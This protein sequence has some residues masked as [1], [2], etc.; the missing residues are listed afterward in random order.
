LFDLWLERPMFTELGMVRK[1]LVLTALLVLVLVAC[2]ST[3]TSSTLTSTTTTELIST[4]QPLA[5]T[6]L[7]TV[8]TP[9]PTA[10]FTPEPVTPLLPGIIFRTAEGVWLVNVRDESELLA[11]VPREGTVD[12]CSDGSYV[13]YGAHRHETDVWVKDYS[14]IEVS[15]GQQVKLEPGEDYVFCSVEWLA[16][17]CDAALAIVEPLSYVGSREC[18]GVPAILDLKSNRL[19]LLGDTPSRHSLFSAVSLDGGAVAFW[20]EDEPWIWTEGGGS[21]VLDLEAYNFPAE[22]VR[23]WNPA[24]SPSGNQVAWIASGVVDGEGSSRGLS[25]LS[26]RQIRHGSYAHIRFG[27]WLM[28]RVMSP[29]VRMATT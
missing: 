1:Q 24:W 14:V 18:W 16:D 20:Q 19:N 22:D 4:A 2:K 6:P 5:L 3:T 29:G 26:W 11:D 17:R 12:V 23:V 21:E 8:E 13:L 25:S 28:G 10:T 27:E 9:M 7:P 15:I